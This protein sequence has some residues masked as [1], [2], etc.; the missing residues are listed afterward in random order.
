MF[1]KK[2]RKVAYSNQST[3]TPARCVTSP[4]ARFTMQHSP[5][6]VLVPVGILCTRKVSNGKRTRPPNVR[7]HSRG[8]CL[9]KTGACCLT[10]KTP[11]RVG[12]HTPR[13]KIYRGSQAGKYL[14]LLAPPGPGPSGAI[15]P[16][17]Y[18][19]AKYPRLYLLYILPAF[20]STMTR[21]PN[22]RWYR[23]RSV[24]P[25]QVGKKEVIKHLRRGWSSLRSTTLTATVVHLS[26]L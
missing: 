22:A 4:A 18:I 11:P 12:Y 21:E 9:E 8:R 2:Y 10:G 5:A 26:D 19:P 14:G 23:G 16:H 15:T 17:R 20:I 24:L 25:N 13:E 3:C 6:Q 1:R 7:C